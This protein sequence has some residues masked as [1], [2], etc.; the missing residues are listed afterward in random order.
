M[1]GIKVRM[2]G[3]KVRADGSEDVNYNA[4]DFPVRSGY[5]CLAIFP[6][7]SAGCHWHRDFE[8]LLAVDNDMNYQVNGVHVPLRKGDAIFVN[9]GR[10]HFGYSEKSQECHYGYAVFHPDFL[11]YNSVIVSILERLASDGNPDYFL[12]TPED[13]DGHA[14]IEAIRFICDHDTVQ[15]ALAI[16]SA[17]AGLLNRVYRRSASADLTPDPDWVIIRAM[18]GYIQAHYQE[19]VQLS[20]IAEAGAVCRSRCCELFRRKLGVSPL[21]YVNRYRLEK[22]CGLLRDGKSITEAGFASGFR[23]ASY[24]S[25]TFRKFYGCTPSDYILKSRDK[26]E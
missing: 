16:Q 4:P 5:S 26:I 24:F 14:A 25:E 9:S 10:L 21:V 1:D 15:E 12:F 23:S 11:G 13:E 20:M 17:C 2:E 18:T 22:A 19:T 6:G 3:F 7:F 8:T